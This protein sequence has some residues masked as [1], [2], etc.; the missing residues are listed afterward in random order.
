MLRSYDT[1]GD[2]WD[3]SQLIF[4]VAS[5]MSLDWPFLRI[6]DMLHI[7][8]NK[9]VDVEHILRETKTYVLW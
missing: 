4:Y 3:K 2:D 1:N 5:Q 6:P 7:H 9:Y 8:H